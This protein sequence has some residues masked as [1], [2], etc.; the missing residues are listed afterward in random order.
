MFTGGRSSAQQFADNQ[1]VLTREILNPAI[2]STIT[3]TPHTAPRTFN[4]IAILM[5]ME[6]CLLEESCVEL[7]LLT[8]R[9]PR[10]TAHPMY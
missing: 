6:E 8:T 7:A 3:A 2:K 1:A 4:S 5:F 10:Y 9:T